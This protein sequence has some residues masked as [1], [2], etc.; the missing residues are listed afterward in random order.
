MSKVKKLHSTTL[1][2]Q[3]KLFSENE[4]LKELLF[5]Q[6]ETKVLS[7]DLKKK[8]NGLISRFLYR[9]LLGSRKYKFSEEKANQLLSKA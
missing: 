1:L 9:V 6:L 7:R 4:K 5:S 3:R 2:K 8:L